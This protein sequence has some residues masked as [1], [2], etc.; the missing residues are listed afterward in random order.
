MLEVHFHG[1]KVFDLFFR[2]LVQVMCDHYEI[3]DP[4]VIRR[5]FF[6]NAEGTLLDYGFFRK[7]WLEKKDYGYI[8]DPKYEAAMSGMT[9]RDAANRERYL[10]LRDQNARE[11]NLA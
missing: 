4:E 2:R 9:A 8:R 11:G 1:K 3:D 7:W 5:L 6:C 10:T